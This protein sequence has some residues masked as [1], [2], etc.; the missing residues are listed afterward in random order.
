MDVSVEQYG[1]YQGQNLYELTFTNDQ[2]MV[3][4]LLN[5]GAT[6]EKVLL[7]E[8]DGLHNMVLSLPTR[9]DYSKE[10]NFLGGTV[11]RIVG[12][13]RGHVWQHGDVKVDLPMNE[14]KNHIHGGD[15]GLDRQVYNFRTEQ[16]ATTASASF[17]FVDPAGHNGYPGNL[18]LQV[19]YTLTN[20][21]ALQYRVDALSDEETLFNPTNHTYFALDQPATIDETVLT[22]PADAYKPLDAEHLPNQG[23]QPVAG[24]V[25][26]FR[27]GQKLGDVI[28]TRADQITSER[29]IN[30]PFL[31]KNGK[32]LAAKLQTKNHTMTLVTTAPSVVVYT[33]NHFDGTGVA[34]NIKQFDGVALECQYPP[35]SGSDLSAITLLP[36]EPFTLA[37]T[38]TFE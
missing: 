18:K 35:V 34:H 15:D 12:R 6:L 33:A 17:T 20:A 30:H 21:N 23:W 29:G 37:N 32:A 38:W 3:V 26:D 11:G 9:E 31:L 10:R 4:K 19:T 14:G 25:F 16:T 5:Y 28:H 22:I 1:Q 8:A 13:I 27:N 2:G 36:G 7:P 24:T